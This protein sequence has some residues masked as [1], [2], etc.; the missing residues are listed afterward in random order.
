MPY[1]CSRR[2][3]RKRPRPNVIVPETQ[4]SQT[5]SDTDAMQPSPQFTEKRESHADSDGDPPLIPQDS[6]NQFRSTRALPN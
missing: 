4:F 5:N 1:T 2:K 6:S 3:R